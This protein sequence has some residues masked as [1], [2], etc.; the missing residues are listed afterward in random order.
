MRRVVPERGPFGMG[1]PRW[2]R[3][4]ADALGVGPEGFLCVDVGRRLSLG[5]LLICFPRRGWEN[6]RFHF[7][8]STAT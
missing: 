8:F 2:S 3:A 6:Y 5:C 1:A 7:I 4:G